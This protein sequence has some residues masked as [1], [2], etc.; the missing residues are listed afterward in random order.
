VRYFTAALI[1]IGFVIAVFSVLA[2][3]TSLA[4]RWSPGAQNTL[5]EVVVWWAQYWWMI[6]MVLASVCLI[7]AVVQDAHAPAKRKR[8]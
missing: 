3:L 1:S 8:Q 4:E 5:A 7:V 6:G 2:I